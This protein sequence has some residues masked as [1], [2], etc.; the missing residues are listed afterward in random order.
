MKGDLESARRLLRSLCEADPDCTVEFDLATN[1]SPQIFHWPNDHNVV[2]VTAE[3]RESIHRSYIT[4][5][6]FNDLNELNAKHNCVEGCVINHYPML[7]I[8]QFDAFQR[9]F[10]SYYGTF[11]IAYPKNDTNLVKMKGYAANP[12]HLI[13]QFTHADMTYAKTRMMARFRCEVIKK[14]ILWIESKLDDHLYNPDF[15]FEGTFKLPPNLDEETF[16][17]WKVLFRSNLEY[18]LWI[19]QHSRAVHIPLR[20]YYNSSRLLLRWAKSNLIPQDAK[21]FKLMWD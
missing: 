2:F 20:A 17:N 7:G 6:Q 11:T 12:I 9:K 18:L 8:A 14:M 1:I 3:S 21:C 15:R 16:A 13:R 10:F 5:C 4:L 19:W